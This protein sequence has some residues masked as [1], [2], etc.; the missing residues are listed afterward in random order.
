MD[1]ETFGEHQWH[2]SGIFDFLSSLPAEWLKNDG[3]DFMT[4]G[5]A[6]QNIEAVDSISMPQTVTWADTER[7][8]SAW[9]GNSM[10]RQAIDALYA[11]E[12]P[13]LSLNDWS[14]IEDWRKLQTSDHFYYMCIKWFNDG[15]IHAYFNPYETPY[16]A[17]INFMNAYHDLRSRMM[18][19]G[20]VL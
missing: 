2:E 10:Q 20:I 16:E 14:L 12:K 1:Y 19:Q 17:Y 11:L 9:I 5:E 6:S 15:D 7:D 3:H 18:D 13:L 8:L 4:I